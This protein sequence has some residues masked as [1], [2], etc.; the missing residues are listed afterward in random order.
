MTGVPRVEPGPGL[1]NEAA[2]HAAFLAFLR[3]TVVGKCRSLTADAQ[4]SSQLPSGW[5]PLELLFHLLHVERR[6]FVWGFLGEDVP[7]PWG[8]SGGDAEAP[9]HVPEGL[10]F[11]DVVVEMETIAARTEAV[12]RTHELDEKS[13]VTGRF[14]GATPPDLRWICFHVLQEYARHAGHLDVAVEIATGRTGE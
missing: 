11:E 8:D 10:T 13:A 12:L 3:D 2:H 14:A 5:T 4:S 9:W 1:P 7:S 6:W